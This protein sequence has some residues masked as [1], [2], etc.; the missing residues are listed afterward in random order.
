MLLAVQEC[1]PEGT[2][3]RLALEAAASLRNLSLLSAGNGL[4]FLYSSSL[5]VSLLKVEGIETRLSEADRSLLQTT[6]RRTAIVAVGEDLVVANV[7]A[8]EPKS[9]P[10]AEALAR[11]FLL[12]CTCA[13]EAAQNVETAPC[14]TAQNVE[15]APRQRPGV[16]QLLLGDTNLPSR[17]LAEAFAAECGRLS[18]GVL[19]RVG[20]PTTRKMRSKL[21]GQRCNKAKTLVLVEAHKDF[22]IVG[23]A[24]GT[25]KPERTLVYPDLAA[26]PDLLLPHAKWAADHSMV[27]VLLKREPQV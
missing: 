9:A 6:I 17:E 3:K 26:E 4:A 14:E 25:W 24:A 11:Y 16:T 27:Q 22:A 7:H 20:T 1:A 12:V 23:P 18:M 5:Q 8:K 21:H 19:P 13:S 10:A 2:A 15:R